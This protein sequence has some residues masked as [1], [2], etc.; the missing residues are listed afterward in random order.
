MKPIH[1]MTALATVLVC[2]PLSAEQLRWH[3]IPQQNIPVPDLTPAANMFSSGMDDLA[4]AFRRYEAANSRREER[5]REERE[6]ERELK[7]VISYEVRPDGKSVECR[8]YGEG[9]FCREPR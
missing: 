4:N 6:R 8:T 5:E 3:N 1:L 2:T 7:P 9:K